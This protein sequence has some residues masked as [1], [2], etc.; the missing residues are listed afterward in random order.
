MLDKQS[1]YLSVNDCSSIKVV[2]HRSA[3]NNKV[4]IFPPSSINY[5]DFI[6][7]FFAYLSLII[8]FFFFQVSSVSAVGPTKFRYSG[9]IYETKSTAEAAMKADIVRVTYDINIDYLVEYREEYDVVN[10]SKIHYYRIELPQTAEE[11]LDQEVWYTYGLPV[12]RTEADAIQRALQEATKRPASSYHCSTPTFNGWTA[13]PETAHTGPPGIITSEY[14]NDPAFKKWKVFHK[15]TTQIIN[16]TQHGWRLFETNGMSACGSP[17]GGPQDYDHSVP[18][19]TKFSVY[20]CPKGYLYRLSGSPTCDLEQREGVIEEL[21]QFSIGIPLKCPPVSIGEG[22]P[23]NPATGSKI[24]TETD[25][26]TAN[27]T[28][29]VQR[30][31]HSQPIGD[32][33]T[34]LGS[35]WRHNYSQLLYGYDD[36]QSSHLPAE[37]S[38]SFY[39]TPIEACSQ[40]WEE[41][42][43][44]YSNVLLD[45]ARASYMNGSCVVYNGNQ[46]VFRLLVNDTLSPRPVENIQYLLRPGGSSNAFL[47]LSDNG[48]WQPFYPSRVNLLQT[49][50]GWNF[51]TADGITEVYN[52]FGRLISSTNKIG[53]TTNFNYDSEGRLSIVTGHFGDTL[54]Y[55]Y[56]DSYLTSITT[57]DGD[58]R[59]GYDAQRRLIQVIYPDS[60]TRQYHYED[61]RLPNHLTGITD[62]NGDRYAT[63]AY[64]AEGRAILSEH[65]GNSERVEFVYNPD[66]TTT[67]TDAAGAERKYHFLVQHGAI[68]V[69][70][71]EGD[72]CTTCSGGDMQA[73]TYDN[74]GFVSSKTDWSGNVTTY[75]NDAQGRELSRTEASGT[76]QARTITTT[77]DTDLNK[78]LVITEPNQITEYSYDPTGRLLNQK[79]RA[80]Q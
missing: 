66:G 65:A 17:D 67:V 29:N 61:A 27:N 42:A 4:D 16:Y 75:D 8:I 35:H 30:T 6:R 74:N 34:S 36:R 60:H 38:S 68:T 7:S 52:E 51:S 25:Y 14:P 26:T 23:C 44:K 11:T 70:H 32:G 50:T 56:V 24:Q 64:D 37:F 13:S 12:M 49:E 10:N 2:W 18:S 58:V 33:F 77:W 46:M 39:D 73:Y 69:D 59:Y 54:T 47:V 55:N 31:Y 9:Q 43:Q 15:I 72:R 20:K 3:N 63:W 71:I 78:P 5:P 28:L 53:Q 19:F 1:S 40:G 48:F 21:S 76:P 57:P 41:I 62:E 22:N 45:E 80:P 79:Q